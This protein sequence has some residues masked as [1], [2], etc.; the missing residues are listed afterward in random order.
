MPQTGFLDC[1]D[2]CASLDAKKDLSGGITAVVPWKA[3]RPVPERVR[4]KAEGVPEIL[5]GAQADGCGWDG[6]NA[7]PECALQNSG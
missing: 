4:R 1:S 7:G 2:G 5:R 6:Q 3:F